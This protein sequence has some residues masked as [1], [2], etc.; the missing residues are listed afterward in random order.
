MRHTPRR[1]ARLAVQV[2]VLMKLG[3]PAEIA[4]SHHRPQCHFRSIQLLRLHQ[5]L[6]HWQMQRVH[7]AHHSP[8]GSRRSGK[9]G[10]KTILNPSRRLHRLTQTQ[11]PGQSLCSHHKTCGRAPFLKLKCLTQQV[12]RRNIGQIT[13]LC[14]IDR[15]VLNK[16]RVRLVC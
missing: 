15:I 8:W 6:V 13:Q 9:V 1:R 11:K 10:S 5:L 4:V 3:R 12:H 16:W 14:P 7:T 2:L